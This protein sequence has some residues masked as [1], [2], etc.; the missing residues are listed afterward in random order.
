MSTAT[1][2]LRDAYD[3]FALIYNRTIAEDFCRR[4][5][6][7]VEQLLLSRIPVG[8]KILD[9]CCGSGQMARELSRRSY[10]VVGLDASPQMLNL[11]QQNAPNAEFVLA[12]ARRFWLKQSFDAVLSSF[13]SL[14]HAAS[15]AELTAIL[16][17]AHAA[18]KPNG[19]FLFDISMEEAYTTKWGGSFGEAHDDLAFVVRPSY[20]SASRLAHNEVTFFQ[21]D[22]TCWQ[23]HDFTITQRCFSESEVRKALIQAG[24]RNLKSHDA[25]RDLGMSGEFG[26]HFFLC[27]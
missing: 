27:R 20:D 1:R 14:A 26:R 13:N 21:H 16:S 15:T 3:P 9:L 11:A 12:D 6:P 2:Q 19:I 24:F 10:G 25:E 4:A 23:R 18:L 17:N 8:A 22:G 7:I 5:W